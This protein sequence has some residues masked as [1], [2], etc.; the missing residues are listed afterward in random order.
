MTMNNKSIEWYLDYILQTLIKNNGE[1]LGEFD[2]GM[3]NL[4][5]FKSIYE[6]MNISLND[7]KELLDILKDDNYASYKKVE[8]NPHQHEKIQLTIK[9][10]LF[11]QRGGYVHQKNH[12]SLESRTLIGLQILLVFGTCGMLVIEI[13]KYVNSHCH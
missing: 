11:R 4:N 5:N 7:F 13:V 6:E 1:I 10:R 2:S 8:S 9:G 12:K 3:S